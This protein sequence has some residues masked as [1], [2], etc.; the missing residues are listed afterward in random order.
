MQTQHRVLNKVCPFS[1]KKNTQIQKGQHGN[2][3]QIARGS[4][5]AFNE[6]VLYSFQIVS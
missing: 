4:N 2:Y 6:C 3:T 1:M 5:K